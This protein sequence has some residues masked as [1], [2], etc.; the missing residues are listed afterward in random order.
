[1]ATGQPEVQAD[2]GRHHLRFATFYVLAVAAAMAAWFAPETWIAR[3]LADRDHWW[4]RTVA[5][6]AMVAIPLLLE[7]AGIQ[8]LGERDDPDA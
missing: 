6:L 3:W 1:M 8:I 2:T 4:V 7:R 5:F